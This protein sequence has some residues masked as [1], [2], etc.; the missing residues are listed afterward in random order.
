MS[1]D[2]DI[3]QALMRHE[4]DVRTDP[5]AFA[6]VEQRVR[7]AHQRRLAATGTFV[8]MLLVAASAAVVALRG[9]RDQGFVGPGEDEAP[10]PS[11]S[12]TPLPGPDSV[13]FWDSASGYALLM[14]DP[15][16]VTEFEGVIELLP[17]G[18]IGLSA[19]EDTFA[20]EIQ[21]RMGEHYMDL[22]TRPGDSS[23]EETELAG[24]PAYKV[25]Y[26]GSHRGTGR[27][28]IYTVDWPSS[29]CSLAGCTNEPNALMIHIVASTPDRW[30]SYSAEAVTAVEGLRA[31]ASPSDVPA[32]RVVTRR[33]VIDGSVAV[34]D[35]V[36]LLV[37]FLEARVHG[38]GA[39]EFLS[40][41][42]GDPYEGDLYTSDGE[43]LLSYEVTASAEGDA[44][45]GEFTVLL[46]PGG[47]TETIGIGAGSDGLEVRFIQ[48]G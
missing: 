3:K 27:G 40:P 8:V 28:V 30:E 9:D 23:E 4:D 10:A 39:E 22:V 1:L 37:L 29:F 41:A 14:P 43:A 12:P 33:G 26:D 16:R 2:H 18:E 25:E 34:D 45:S 7:R 6:G 42:F 44:N 13:T 19:G 5:D 17:P 32:G 36:Q 47:V 11:A 15:W 48:R 24:R 31:T 21:L 38:G 35:R 20:V 46:E